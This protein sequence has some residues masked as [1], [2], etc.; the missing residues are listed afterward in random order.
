MLNTK[1]FG[2]S[3]AVVASIK[4]V[5]QHAFFAFQ[6]SGTGEAS[7]DATSLLV[8][9]AITAVTGFVLGFLFAHIYNSLEKKIK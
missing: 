6:M 5:L 2:I 4:L 8:S 3:A 7:F 9:V 1:V